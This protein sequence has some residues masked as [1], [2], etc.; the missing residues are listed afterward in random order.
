[1][2]IT[3]LDHVQLAAPPGCEPAARKFFG[4]LL[5]LPELE[6]PPALA[7]RGGAWFAVGEHGQ[8]L[9][10]GVTDEHAPA[11]K[12]HPAFAATELDVLADRLAAAG[13][14]VRWDTELSA[15]AAS[16]STIPGATGSSCSPRPDWHRVGTFAPCRGAGRRRT[17]ADARTLGCQGPAG[18]PDPPRFGLAASPVASRAESRALSC[19]RW[20]SPIARFRIGPRTAT[21][22]RSS[23]TCTRSAARPAARHRTSSLL[24]CTPDRTRRSG[25]TAGLWRGLVKWQTV[26]RSRS[27]RLASPLPVAPRR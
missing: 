26:R 8:Q 10:I 20:G 1:M 7:A 25:L 14:E 6:K 9:H 23:R 19:S 16:T 22:I 24:S 18:G 3:A 11:H 2:P 4:E 12:A 27:R 15:S 21:C 13:H 17:W 5:G